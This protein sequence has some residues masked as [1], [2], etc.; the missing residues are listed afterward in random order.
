M[1]VKPRTLKDIIDCV[2]IY[3][4]YNDFSFINMS[5]QESIKSISQFVRLNKFMRIKLESDKVVAWILCDKAKPMHQEEIQFQQIYFASMNTGIKAY[6]DVI[7]LHNEMLKETKR[8]GLKMAISS[9][10]HMDEKFTFTRM[11]ERNG[12]QRRGYV[13]LKRLD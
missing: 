4:S 12:W 11:L 10:S 9:G 1:I 6:R 3:E 2:N 8:L 13:A 5:T 7:D